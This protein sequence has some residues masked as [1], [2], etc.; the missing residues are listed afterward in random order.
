M[1]DVIVIGAG[2]AGLTA[3]REFRQAGKSVQIL[4]ASDRIGG[5]VRSISDPHAGI[6]LELGA[7]FL[8]GEAKESNKLLREARLATVPVL[9]EH[10]RSR[11]GKFESQDKV[12][13]R[14]ARVFKRMDD[15]RKQ[16]RS[17]QDFLDT[18]PGGPLYKEEREL[19]LG[20]V[21]GFNG[22]DAWRISERSLAEQ[23]NP[24]EGAAKSARILNGYGALIDFIATDLV[25]VIQFNS[26][27]N[28]ILW[29]ESRVSVF[30]RDGTQFDARTC[31]ITIPLPHL[32]DESLAIES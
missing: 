14:M 9:G 26:V 27:V 24:T 22:A 11:N 23:G 10:Y 25:D 12:W 16:D 5:R 13:N 20:F 28:R 19:A 8:H 1:K 15:D 7:E 18:K 2:A 21:Q 6:P 29:D 30:T 4:E 3:A 32:Q 17:F 31:V